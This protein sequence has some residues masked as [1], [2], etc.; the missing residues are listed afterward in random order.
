V[1]VDEFIGHGSYCN[2]ADVS[3][4]GTRF[5]TASNDTT[6]LIWSFADE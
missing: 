4:D 5:V 1:L 6:A 2:A 3:P